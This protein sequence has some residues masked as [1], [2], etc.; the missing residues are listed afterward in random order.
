[1]SMEINPISKWSKF[2]PVSKL[3]EANTSYYII[4]NTLCKSPMIISFLDRLKTFLLRCFPYE[5]YN[6]TIKNINT[7]NHDI[8]LQ[9]S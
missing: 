2:P 7:N 6:R 1:M 9:V 8:A 4:A 5:R 3:D